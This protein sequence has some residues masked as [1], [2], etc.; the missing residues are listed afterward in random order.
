MRGRPLILVVDDDVKITNLVKLYL[1]RTGYRAVCAHDGEGVSGLDI[2]RQIRRQ[3]D[4]P[5]IMLT[6]RSTEQDKVLGLELGADDY[7]T[8]PFSP[9]EL[10]A[11]VRTV[12][13]RAKLDE[14]PSEPEEI[15]VGSLVLR[16]A[17]Y[18]V[19]L[20]GERVNLT[21]TEFRLL[22]VLARSPG[23]A[24]SRA[25]LLDLA[26]DPGF[27]GCERNVD[28]HIMNL[29]RKLRFTADHPIHAVHGVGYR[30]EG[31]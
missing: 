26:F 4:L 15:A 9:R 10:T 11:R 5:I 19:L 21:R 25:Q 29:R 31:A 17:S 3:S 7:V 12:L 20:E 2:C 28:V 16:P 27:E 8:K 18:E 30:F 23:R 22:C 13:R 14:K 24:F 6:A 1:E